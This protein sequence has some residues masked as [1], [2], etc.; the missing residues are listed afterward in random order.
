MQVIIPTAGRGTRLLPHTLTKPKQLITVAGKAVLGHIIDSFAGL[1][2][3]EYVFV[4]GYLGEQIEAY[5]KANYDIPARFVE[6]RD[7]L[8]QAHALLLCRDYLEGPA[9]IV[10]S[11]TLTE[12]DYSKLATELADAVIYVKEVDDPRRFGIVLLDKQGFITRYVEKPDAP[13]NNFA[14][15]GMYFVKDSQL[16]MTCCQDLM[17]RNIQFKGEYYI[18][19]AFNLMIAEHGARF[20]PQV[21]DV[22]EDCG[23][24]ETLLQTNRYLL[25]HGHSSHDHIPPCNS[26]VIPPIHLGK[27]VILEDAVI[28]PYASLGDNAVV[29]RAIVRD[30][31][32]GRNSRVEDYILAG[33]LIG[34][35]AVVRGRPQKLNV[36][37]S[38]EIDFGTSEK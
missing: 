34:D 27:G 12:T 5:V 33:S 28:G 36:G 13:E 20:R 25:E 30:S 7:P 14:T 35:F 15:I 9:L 8:G 29:R 11:D 26:I 21:V 23:K 22:W 31:I 4:V 1:K 16:L 37:D 38:S 18:A 19:D 3:N 24:P 2:V 32:I 6:Q 17:D 10:F